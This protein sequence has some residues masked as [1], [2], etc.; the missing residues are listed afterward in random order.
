VTT[1]LASAILDADRS[2]AEPV[3]NRITDEPVR[4]SAKVEVAFAKVEVA[5]LRYARPFEPGA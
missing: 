5:L 3:I 4:A 2:K 1:A